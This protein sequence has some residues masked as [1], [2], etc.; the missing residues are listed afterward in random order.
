MNPGLQSGHD[1]IIEIINQTNRI[2]QVLGL[3]LQALPSDAE[4]QEIAPLQSDGQRQMQ[5]NLLTVQPRTDVNQGLLIHINQGQLQ[6]ARQM[7]ILEKIKDLGRRTAGQARHP[8][9]PLRAS[10]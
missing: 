2:H 5:H 9:R 7:R 3:E 8:Q 10:I 6:L 4:M 1:S